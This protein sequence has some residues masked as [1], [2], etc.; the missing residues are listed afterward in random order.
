[1][2]TFKHKQIETL[3]C[4]KF[5]LTS[6]KMGKFTHFKN[7]ETEIGY[8]EKIS[9][10]KYLYTFLISF[11]DFDNITISDEIIT[12]IRDLYVKQKKEIDKNTQGVNIC[13]ELRG[14]TI[15]KALII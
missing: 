14:N 12:F 1:M 6:Y 9:S 13:L 5:N 11:F 8:I 10:K 7:T 4:D 15:N 3:T 2:K